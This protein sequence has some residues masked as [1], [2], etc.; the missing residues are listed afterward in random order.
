M[1]FCLKRH[2]WL[3]NRTHGLPVDSLSTAGDVTGFKHVQLEL[4]RSAAQDL[5]ARLAPDLTAQLLAIFRAYA[6]LPALSDH[7]QP[8]VGLT[9]RH[10]GSAVAASGF[11]PVTD[12]HTSFQSAE[13]FQTPAVAI[14]S[15]GQAPP[16]GG[17]TADLA[18]ATQASALGD[19]GLGASGLLSPSA[20][21]QMDFEP[22]AAV[23]QPRPSLVS[24]SDMAS[25]ASFSSVHF[26]TVRP[27]RPPQLP[28][29][30]SMG[31]TVGL[32]GEDTSPS[33]VTMGQETPRS[34]ASVRAQAGHMQQQIRQ[35]ARHGHLVV[36]QPQQT[37]QQTSHVLVMQGS[38][39][40]EGCAVNSQLV[41][42]YLQSQW[43]LTGMQQDTCRHCCC[44][45]AESIV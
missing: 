4:Y 33:V 6:R 25:P 24:F 34:I 3:R 20:L 26:P 40:L 5:L 41:P 19:S 7:P 12:K 30:L 27:S 8:A 13:P 11:D 43:S 18:A 22:I 37:V 10:A 38:I 44:A 32:L 16:V 36:L 42:G 2:N 45:V 29:I 17:M 39:S 1:A 15:M 21:S 35:D 31:P 14:A 28:S 23:A 9:A